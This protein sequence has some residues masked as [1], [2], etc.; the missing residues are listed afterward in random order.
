MTY[1][2][3]STLTNLAE[4]SAMEPK[5]VE[6]RTIV[7]P[8]DEGLDLD[9]CARSTILT[10]MIWSGR[11]VLGTAAL[12]HLTRYCLPQAAPLSHIPSPAAANR[13]LDGKC[14]DEFP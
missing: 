7:A 14:D 5:A 10:W 9:V 3:N 11:Q 13:L 4:G 6:E 2:W 8:F 1:C 12:M